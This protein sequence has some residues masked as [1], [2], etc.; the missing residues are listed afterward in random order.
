MKKVGILTFHYADNYGAVLQAYALRK[1]IN[2]MENCEAELINYIPEDYYYLTYE[3]GKSGKALLEKKRN[4]FD[5]FLEQ[6]CGITEERCAEIQEE[7]YDYI[8][9]GSD[10]VWNLDLREN[11]QRA[12]FLP[13]V[14]DG[15][16]C[17]SYA[18]SIGTDIK[19]VNYKVFEEN[20]KKFKAVSLRETE[21]YQKLLK[22]KCGINSV[23]VL[24]PTLLLNKADYEEIIKN[25]K[26]EKKEFIFLFWY[27]LENNLYKYTEFVNMLS[28]KYNLPI[29][30][31]VLNAPDYLFEFNGGCMLYEGVEDF[32][33][34]M[35][36]A[37]YVVT[38]S[39]HGLALAIQFNKNFYLIISKFRRNRLDH[40]VKLLGLEDRVVENFIYPKD[41]N[42]EIDYLKIR[43]FLESEKR[44]SMNYL[45]GVLEDS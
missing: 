4:K 22:E 27:D 43:D 41:V 11:S 45:K 16:K 35:K 13:N 17:F 21:G 20:I 6:W 33:W 23:E 34:Y 2:E 38:N 32:L 28:R 31:T 14:C 39:F 3:T 15:C 10:Q 24:D 8:C 26:K 12:Y 25:V 40:L 7:L 29:I 37:K 5:L 1:V 30:H 19:E 9:V 44:K 42:W 18:A 36:N